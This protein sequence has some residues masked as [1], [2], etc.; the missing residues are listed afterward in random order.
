MRQ[1]VQ[2]GINIARD[3]RVPSCTGY[4]SWFHCNF[5]ISAA[6]R[7]EPQ[8]DHRR[9]VRRSGAHFETGGVRARTKWAPNAPRPGDAR[10][11]ATCITFLDELGLNVNSGDP[12]GDT[13][14]ILA[15]CFDQID[16]ARL[17]IEK[18]SAQVQL[19]GSQGLTA[20]EY[21]VRLGSEL[22]AKAFDVARDTGTLP[23]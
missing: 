1:L 11:Y 17:L 10:Q 22:V 14:L 12:A 2:K 23:K 19:R 15:A 6:G 3:V 8:G 13:P 9:A 4:R 20:A 18:Y 7:E 21:A 16:A 5:D